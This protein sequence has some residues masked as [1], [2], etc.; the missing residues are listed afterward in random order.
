M[1]T[2]CAG[3][4]EASPA[5]F[6]SNA[7]AESGR[8]MSQF[9]VG[10]ERACKELGPGMGRPGAAEKAHL[11]VHSGSGA[12]QASAQA[13]SALGV[14]EQEK[15]ASGGEGTKR[16]EAAEELRRGLSRLESTL[17]GLS[18]AG[19]GAEGQLSCLPNAPLSAAGSGRMTRTPEEVCAQGSLP[20]I[21]ASSMEKTRHGRDESM[22]L[23]ALDLMNT[24]HRKYVHLHSVSGVGGLKVAWPP[25]LDHQWLALCAA[26]KA[27]PWGMRFPHL[28]EIFQYFFL[29]IFALLAIPACRSR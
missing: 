9:S 15:S 28:I 6:G 10:S 27:I 2:P 29:E 21:A 12:E 7:F 3:S 8:T 23:L 20:L 25:A 19:G 1:N 16:H 18:V 4:V 22:P 26:A 24:S 13:C 5:S 11:Q 14:S 17:P